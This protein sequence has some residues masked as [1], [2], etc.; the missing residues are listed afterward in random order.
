M[1]LSACESTSLNKYIVTFEPNNGQASYTSEYEAN[2]LILQPT[3]PTRENH[4]FDT[5]YIDSEFS[6]K[7]DFNA[8]KVTSDMT[9]YAKWI[10]KTPAFYTITFDSQGGSEFLPISSAPNGNLIDFTGSIPYKE[11][12]EFKGWYKDADG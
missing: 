1:I 6:L 9:L 4:D 2:Q 11:G 3:N 7:W 10:E 8:H 12:H 5:W